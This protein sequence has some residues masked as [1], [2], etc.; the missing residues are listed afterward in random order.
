MINKDIIFSGEK[1][2]YKINN[3]W[4]LVTEVI[5]TYKTGYKDITAIVPKVIRRV[6]INDIL[7]MIER[8]KK[9][10]CILRKD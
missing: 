4:Y 10:K 7:S 3:D 2:Y 1:V 9:L 8:I 5:E 6:E